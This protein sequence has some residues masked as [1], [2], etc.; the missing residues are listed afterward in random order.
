[1]LPDHNLVTTLLTVHL[2][3][4]HTFLA[5]INLACHCHSGLKQEVRSLMNK[6]FDACM[7]GTVFAG[8]HLG[9]RAAIPP[10]GSRGEP[11]TKRR[12]LR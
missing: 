2:C 10:G 11:V 6:R 4:P 5:V 7:L 12:N 1:M 8:A 9:C 3:L